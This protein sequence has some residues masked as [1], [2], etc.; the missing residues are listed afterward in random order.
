M[1]IK[2]GP[3]FEERQ[4]NCIYSQMHIG[5]S[6]EYVCSFAVINVVVVLVVVSSTCWLHVF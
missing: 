1:S 3:T 2:D 4:G 6:L 5:S